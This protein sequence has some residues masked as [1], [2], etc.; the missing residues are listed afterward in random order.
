MQNHDKSISWLPSC[1]RLTSLA[2]VNFSNS[3]GVDMVMER[4]LQAE[5]EILERVEEEPTSCNLLRMVI[6]AMS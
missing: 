4:I 6:T 5:E 3:R 1:V 2:A